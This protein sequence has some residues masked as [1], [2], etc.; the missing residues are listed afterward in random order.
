MNSKQI[1]AITALAV[2]LAAS[3]AAT[4]AGQAEHQAAPARAHQ[5]PLEGAANFRDVGGY[6]TADGHHVKRGL[7]YRSN[8]LGDLTAADY[9]FLN[10][11]GIK[12]VCD[13]RT[14]GERQRTPTR[15]QGGPAP[16]I[17]V[18]QILKDAD[19]VMTP[20]RLKELTSADRSAASLA[21]SYDQ[22]IVPDAAMEYGKVYRRIASGDVPVI[23]HCSAGKDRTGVFSAVLLTMLGV[24]RK[25]V[26]DDYMLTGEYMLTPKALTRAVADWQKLTG[27]SEPPSEATIRALYEMHA[28]VITNTFATI[29]RTYGSFDAFVRDGLKLT[30]SEVA[31]IRARM[32]E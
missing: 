30:P 18:A 21:M 19:V 11:R 10:A 26:V 17:M 27:A 4:R 2:S 28:E 5:S 15:W 9:A 14:A 1:T 3:A 29:D 13:F 8:H 20:E 23:G 24:P 31:A 6:A 16:E 12:L 22:M 32:L 25:T 7:V